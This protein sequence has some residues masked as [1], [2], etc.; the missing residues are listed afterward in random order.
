MPGGFERY[1]T[2]S[3][4]LRNC[5]PWYTVGRNPLPQQLSPPLGPLLP[6]LNTTKPGRSLVSDPSPY[7]THAPML[8][9]PNCIVPVFISSWPGAWLNASVTIDFTIAMSSAISPVNGSSS[10]NSVPL[11]PY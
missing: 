3:P 11:C 10:L 9:R 7:S 5:T 8:G 6:E 4:P 1:R 2:G